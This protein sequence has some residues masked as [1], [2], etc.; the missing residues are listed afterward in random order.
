MVKPFSPAPLEYAPDGTAYS[1][2]YDDIYHSTA[3]GLEQARH[4]FVKGN[5][6]PLRWQAKERFTLL[7]TGFGMGLNFLATWQAWQADPQR[8]CYL[9]YVA[10]ELHPFSAADLRILHAQW[11]ELAPLADELHA[12]WPPLFP[13]AHHLPLAGGRLSLSL[14][15]GDAA[16]LLPHLETRYDALYLDGFAPQKNPA[17]WS[18]EF[19][20]E[21][22]RHAEKDATLATWCVAGAVRRALSQAG[23]SLRREAGFGGKREMLCGERLLASASADA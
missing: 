15:F 6:L 1:T 3:G 18:D 14:L 7:E 22:S 23:W 9:H 8:S 20:A 13:G 10:A 11:P 12:A 5:R 16:Q 2:A 17:L 21:I 4:V 19:I